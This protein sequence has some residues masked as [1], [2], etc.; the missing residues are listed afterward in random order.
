MDVRYVRKFKDEKT[1]CPS[2]VVRLSSM[3]Q[4]PQILDGSVSCIQFI[5]SF[6]D[7]DTKF[8]MCL[9]TKDEAVQILNGLS[10]FQQCRLGGDLKPYDPLKVEELI[11][12]TC[13]S[14]PT[15]HKE[16]ERNPMKD[17]TKDKFGRPKPRVNVPALKDFFRTQ[18]VN[19]GVIYFFN[20]F[21]TFFL[22]L[23]NI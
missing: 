2:D 5:S 9:K 17:T 6:N 4:V 11:K 15:K 22:L 7:T 14:I 8:S 23:L 10:N 18:L 19:A 20:F 13:M 3:K 16:D 1:K 12:A 21:I